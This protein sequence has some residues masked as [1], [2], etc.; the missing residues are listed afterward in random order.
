MSSVTVQKKKKKYW[1]KRNRTQFIKILSIK[2]QKTI[3]HFNEY[4]KEKKKLKIKLKQHKKVT[5]EKILKKYFCGKPFF[6]LL[7]F[8]KWQENYSNKSWIFVKSC[9]FL[10]PKKGRF[11]EQPLFSSEIQI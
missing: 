4:F 1:R 9:Y 5:F 11:K 2:G 8:K 7:N 6:N 3:K 10:E